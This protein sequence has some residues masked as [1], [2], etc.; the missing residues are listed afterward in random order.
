MYATADYTAGTSATGAQVAVGPLT[1]APVFQP[2][3][4]APTMPP[5]AQVDASHCVLL[6]ENMVLGAIR[7]T[8]ERRA[9]EPCTQLS[10][11]GN[12]PRLCLGEVTD[13]MD[14][15]VRTDWLCECQPRG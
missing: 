3:S 6:G 2:I 14:A 13:D 8:V 1:A 12:A 15:A 9:W 10:E 4:E 7:V 11:V 5:L